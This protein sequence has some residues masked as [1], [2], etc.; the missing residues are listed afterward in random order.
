MLDQGPRLILSFVGNQM[1]N[2]EKNEL[3]SL[4][5]FFTVFMKNCGQDQIKSSIEKIK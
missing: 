5:L 3:Q 2:P 1:V 4:L